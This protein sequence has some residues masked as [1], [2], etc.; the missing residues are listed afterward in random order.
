MNKIFKLTD[1]CGCKEDTSYL[2]RMSVYIS[3]DR[4]KIDDTTYI[5]NQIDALVEV[6][7]FSPTQAKIAVE[8][9]MG[10]DSCLVYEGSQ[11]DASIKLTALTAHG[12][13]CAI[14]GRGFLK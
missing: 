6:M 9:A 2:R 11:I 4:L 10:R 7:D 14:K 1:D 13:E 12:I 3:V 5:Q 8:F